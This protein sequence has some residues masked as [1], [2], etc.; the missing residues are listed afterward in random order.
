[1]IVFFPCGLI[2]IRI[3]TVVFVSVSLLLYLSNI[4]KANVSEFLIYYSMVKQNLL[5]IGQSAV[6]C[7]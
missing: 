7:L 2:C 3:L 6:C 5:H 1:M 4:S